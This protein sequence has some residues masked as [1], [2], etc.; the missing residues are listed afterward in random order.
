MN[1]YFIHVSQIL[2][3]TIKLYLYVINIIIKMQHHQQKSKSN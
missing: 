3:I 2:A 1:I